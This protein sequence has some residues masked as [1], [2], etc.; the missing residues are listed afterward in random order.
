MELA[1][2]T[3]KYIQNKIINTFKGNMENANECHGA[4]FKH[5]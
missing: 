2:V 4:L 3:D 5:L 1:L